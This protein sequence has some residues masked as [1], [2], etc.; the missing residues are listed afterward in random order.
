MPLKLTESAF[1]M[2]DIQSTSMTAIQSAIRFFQQQRDESGRGQMLSRQSNGGRP[3][4]F[5]LQLRPWIFYNEFRD[6][7]AQ[8]QYAKSTLSL[9]MVSR[10][11][12]LAI[13]VLDDDDTESIIDH[14]LTSRH[15][16][17]C[18][19]M[20][21][22]RAGKEIKLIYMA[23]LQFKWVLLGI[24]ISEQVIGT[25]ERKMVDI[26]AKASHQWVS[27]VAMQSAKFAILSDTHF[28]GNIGL[29]K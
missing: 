18:K 17:K 7:T 9:K 12:Q 22:M 16:M 10:K 8:E 23:L 28:V 27:E 20:K 25:K 24:R 3:I 11:C 1:T 21:A 2:M 13:D 19:Q 15:L 29:S 14:C 5:N 26:I 4:F 6:G